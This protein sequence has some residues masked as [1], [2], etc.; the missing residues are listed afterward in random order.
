[1]PFRCV[2]CC[3]PVNQIQTRTPV[4][5]ILNYFHFR[6]S[7]NWSAQSM[8][9][10]NLYLC[11]CVL[12]LWLSNCACCELIRCFKYWLSWSKIQWTKIRWWYLYVWAA[13]AYD[14]QRYLFYL[15]YEQP[16]A[17]SSI[18]RQRNRTCRQLENDWL[19]LL[20]GVRA[21]SRC[22]GMFEII[23]DRLSFKIDFECIYI[24]CISWTWGKH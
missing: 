24:L 11:V 20:F 21:A 7:S 9:S 2:W 17:P 12:L 10:L 22:R 19:Q 13:Q 18:V 23:L 16:R 5:L 15:R 8:I 6:H 14:R 4:H 1:M 3:A